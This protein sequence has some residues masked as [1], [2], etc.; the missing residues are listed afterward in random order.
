MAST[1]QPTRQ[2][3]HIIHMVVP[4]ASCYAAI[5]KGT[6]AASFVPR[7]DRTITGCDLIADLDDEAGYGTQRQWRLRS[8]VNSHVSTPEFLDIEATVD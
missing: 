3:L 6:T 4:A 7:N 8:S 1:T 5:A 2:L